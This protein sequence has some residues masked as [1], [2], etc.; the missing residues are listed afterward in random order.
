MFN[1]LAMVPQNAGSMN[2]LNSRVLNSSEN[3]RRMLDYNKTDYQDW[4]KNRR[5]EFAF[6]GLLD[7]FDGSF[8]PATI[9][10]MSGATLAKKSLNLRKEKSS[11]E[12]KL[13]QC[14]AIIENNCVPSG[15]ACDLIK[16]GLL[17]RDLKG[18]LKTLKDY[19]TKAD[20]QSVQEL[21]RNLSRVVPNQGPQATINLRRESFNALLAM[22]PDMKIPPAVAV[23][24]VTQ[25]TTGS[26]NDAI[27]NDALGQIMREQP[28]QDDITFGRLQS[29]IV[30]VTMI[31]NIQVGMGDS[32]SGAT[33]VAPSVMQVSVLPGRQ[34]TKSTEIEWIKNECPRHPWVKTQNGC[35]SLNECSLRDSKEPFPSSDKPT[36]WR[37]GT[38]PKQ[39]AGAK[40]G[41]RHNVVSDSNPG[42]AN[43]S[44]LMM[45]NNNW[46]SIKRNGYRVIDSNNNVSFHSVAQSPPPTQSKSYEGF[47]SSENSF[48]NSPNQM[49]FVNSQGKLEKLISGNNSNPNI[50]FDV[51]RQFSW[52]NLN[53]DVSNINFAMCYDGDPIRREKEI[54]KFISKNNYSIKNN[55]VDFSKINLENEI[56]IDPYKSEFLNTI[57]GQILAQSRS[58]GQDLS[59]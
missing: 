45:S 26:I 6:H 55:Y 25:A 47:S 32:G 33:N 31:K 1:N 41:F 39:Y 7:W 53:K 23:V 42:P 17:E 13:T 2:K 14:L 59:F 28:G 58:S 3:D 50:N 21:L 5:V 16:Q 37:K 35:H 27:I 44:V 12:S 57:N 29:E 34:T 18:V 36:P 56:K 8:I 40:R 24:M 15:T 38:S 20:I 30:K 46:P 49:Y 51:H 54:P 22:Y 9:D 10:E 43:G 19:F 52:A 4:L 11:E 48:Q